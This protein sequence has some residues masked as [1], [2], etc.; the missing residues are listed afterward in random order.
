M[1]HTYEIP[2][3]FIDGQIF[4]KV[5]DSATLT[6]FL[7]NCD[8]AGLFTNPIKTIGWCSSQF[9]R[10]WPVFLHYEEDKLLNPPRMRVISH[11]VGNTRREGCTIPVEDLLVTPCDAGDILDLL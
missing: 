7:V 11:G 1:N 2:Q 3:S 6:D 9:D 8:F 10:G 4:I 5:T